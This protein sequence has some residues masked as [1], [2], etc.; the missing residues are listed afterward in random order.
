MPNIMYCSGCKKQYIAEESKD[1]ENCLIGV[2]EIPISYCFT[3]EDN[4]KRIIIAR[5]LDG[6]LYRLVKC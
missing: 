1:H 4:G 6:I 2:R 3:S 5:G